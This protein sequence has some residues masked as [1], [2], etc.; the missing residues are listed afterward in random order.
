VPTWTATK[1][2]SSEILT[3]S[4]LN[5]YIGTSGNLDVLKSSIAD[6]G[7]LAGILFSRTTA[8]FVK[9]AN[10]TL[11][12]VTGLSFAIGSNDVWLFWVGA[13]GI[14][15]TIADWKVGLTFPSGASGRWSALTGG[16]G[17]NQKSDVIA[18]SL[19]CIGVGS[20]EPL[21]MFGTVVNSSTAG[22]VQV[23]AAQ[24]TSHA[25]NTTIYTNSHIL[26][27]KVA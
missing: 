18:N 25:S 13:S 9:N 19:N 22:T 21:I 8:D 10:T 16:S 14:S 23:Q 7:T 24:N 4:G 5:Q 17:G 2:W 20:D 3:D 6:D 1:T 27:I 15:N 11:A 12:D 26:A